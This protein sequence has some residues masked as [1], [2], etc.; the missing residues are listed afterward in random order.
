MDSCPAT[1]LR[2]DLE[3]RVDVKT[4]FPLAVAVKGTGETVRIHL[5]GLPS[6]IVFKTV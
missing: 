2:V 1:L 6:L 4:C 5:K 3:Y